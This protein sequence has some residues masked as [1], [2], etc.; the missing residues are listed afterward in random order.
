[1]PN[2]STVCCACAV[3]STTVTIFLL[4]HSVCHGPSCV[5]C[6]FLFVLLFWHHGSNQRSLLWVQGNSDPSSSSFQ[7]ILPHRFSVFL[8]LL[9][10]SMGQTSFC[11]LCF[12]CAWFFV[13]QWDLPPLPWP[14]KFFPPLQPL[15]QPLIFNCQLWLSFTMNGPKTMEIVPLIVQENRLKSS[16]ECLLIPVICHTPQ[17]QNTE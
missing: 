14:S 3:T 10:W 1:M 5:P 8:D 2:S 12:Q 15:P 17:C 6:P 16:R 11:C 9:H 13:C 4:H 7:E